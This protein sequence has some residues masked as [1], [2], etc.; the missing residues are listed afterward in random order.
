MS[1]NYQIDKL[2]LAILEVLQRDARTSFLEIARKLVV[3]GGTIHQRVDRMK[4]MGVIKGSHLE[5]DYS[6]LGYGVNVLLGVHLK[7][8]KDATIT[9]EKLEALKEVTEI[10]YT[11][12]NYA[13]IIKVVTKDID[14]F[15]QFLVKKLQSI[16]SISSTESFI[17]LSQPLGRKLRL[18]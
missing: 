13:L 11:T 9:I 18:A 14:S 3:S 7:S 6:K 16:S 17:C 5:V 1:E 12:G 8:A 4:E 10:Y 2:D 15:H